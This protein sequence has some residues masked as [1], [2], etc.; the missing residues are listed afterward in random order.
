MD[1]GA[2]ILVWIL[3]KCAHTYQA[4]CCSD[5][6]LHKQFSTLG[7]RFVYWRRGILHLHRQFFFTL[8]FRV[9]LLEPALSWQ[10]ILIPFSVILPQLWFRKG[11][12]SLF[13]LICRAKSMLSIWISKAVFIWLKIHRIYETSLIGRHYP[14]FSSEVVLNFSTISWTIICRTQQN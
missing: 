14:I 8:E 1:M 3:L 6:H 12:Y 13:Q 10:D 4:L 9:G 2:G 11:I 7:F 5:L